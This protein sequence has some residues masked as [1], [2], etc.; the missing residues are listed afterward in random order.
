MKLN[1]G[2]EA[3]VMTDRKWLTRPWDVHRH[4]VVGEGDA[5]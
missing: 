5:E 4:E 1:E 2:V 3:K